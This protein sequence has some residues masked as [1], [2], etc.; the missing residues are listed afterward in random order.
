M[1]HFWSTLWTPFSGCWRSTAAVPSNFILVEQGG[2]FD[3]FLLAELMLCWSITDYR[4]CQQAWGFFPDPLRLMLADAAVLFPLLIKSHGL[5][6]IDLV[7]GQSALTFWDSHKAEG[8]TMLA[9]RPPTGN[10]SKTHIQPQKNAS[11]FSKE[12]VHWLEEPRWRRSRTGRTLSPPQ[13][14]QKSI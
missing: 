8:N 1:P 7:L 13:N 14:H 11:F 3:N 4:R 5:I 2:E 9:T 12:S 10:I 6:I